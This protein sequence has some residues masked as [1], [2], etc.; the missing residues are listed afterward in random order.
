[1]SGERVVVYAGDR[2]VYP[3]MLTATK[4]LLMH[5]RIDKVYLLIEDDDFRFSCRNA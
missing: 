1:M 3:D 2:N 4:S 5:N